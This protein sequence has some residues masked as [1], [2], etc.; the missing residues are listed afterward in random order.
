MLKLS[1]DGI[2]FFDTDTMISVI[3]LFDPADLR[4]MDSPS[5]HY[6]VHRHWIR[7]QRWTILNGFPGTD[8]PIEFFEDV[9]I[10][11][12]EDDDPLSDSDSF[13][14]EGNGSRDE[15]HLKDSSLGPHCYTHGC[16][17][18]FIPLSVEHLA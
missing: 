10:I 13:P 4:K 3:R 18:Q 9:T 16:T 2:I 5:L 8:D 17:G 14:Y 7:H 15:M 11:I 6:Q 1:V 12:N